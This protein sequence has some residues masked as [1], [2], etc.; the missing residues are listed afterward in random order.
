MQSYLC[1]Q[2]EFKTWPNQ[3]D[4]LP[5]NSSCK[6]GNGKTRSKIRSGKKSHAQR[7]SSHSLIFLKQHHSKRNMTERSCCAEQ[8]SRRS[9]FLVYI[10][11][12][13]LPA[14]HHTSPHPYH[15][16][17][18]ITGMQTSTRPGQGNYQNRGKAGLLRSLDWNKYWWRDI[19]LFKNLSGK[20]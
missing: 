13:D 3:K 19:L 16:I 11:G 2:I 8:L 10:T 20:Q 7:D 6:N 4:I 17:H 1:E 15:C 5:L 14:W 18:V 12:A 9:C